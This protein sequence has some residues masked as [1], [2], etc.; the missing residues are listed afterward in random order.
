[1]RPVALLSLATRVCRGILLLQ[2]RKSRGFAW[3]A[4]L[5]QTHGLSQVGIF[6]VAVVM[7]VIESDMIIASS[8]GLTPSAL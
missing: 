2:G 4:P 5:W 7:V 8:L 1:V 3:T 6:V